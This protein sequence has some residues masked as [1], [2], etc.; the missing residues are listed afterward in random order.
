M[1]HQE[2]GEYE[3]LIGMRHGKPWQYLAL[4]NIIS[5]LTVDWEI[6]CLRGF[7]STSPREALVKCVVVWLRFAVPSVCTILLHMNGI[8]GYARSRAL[9]LP[10]PFPFYLR[11]GQN[12]LLY[13]SRCPHCE[14]RFYN[15]YIRLMLPEQVLPLLFKWNPLLQLQ[16]W[17]P[18][19]FLQLCWQFPLLLTHSF[20]SIKKNK[21]QQ[22]ERNYCK[23]KGLWFTSSCRRNKVSSLFSSTIIIIRK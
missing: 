11:N 6:F 9:P 7:T 3:T 18:K 15:L 16:R 17:L 5:S 12:F 1:K 8:P 14:L 19:R 10:S 23:T 13:G 21:T 2:S 22:R 4:A 20:M